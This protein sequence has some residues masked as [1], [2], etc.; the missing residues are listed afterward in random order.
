[1]IQIR[2]IS[3]FTT[4]VKVNVKVFNTY[5]VMVS[6]P[7]EYDLDRSNVKVTET[8][9]W[10]L[11]LGHNC[12]LHLCGHLLVKGNN[13]VPIWTVADCTVIFRA[14]LSEHGLFGWILIGLIGRRPRS[15]SPVW[16]ISEVCDYITQFQIYVTV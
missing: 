8:A 5:G 9:H 16:L 1:M 3:P 7:R 12:A 13:Y 11:V 2:K 4:L 6:V 15:S 14:H 10:V